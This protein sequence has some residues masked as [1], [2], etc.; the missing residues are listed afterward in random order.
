MPHGSF[1]HAALPHVASPHVAIRMFW[2]IETSDCVNLLRVSP[3]KASP[4][5]TPMPMICPDSQD[6]RAGPGASLDRHPAS[7]ALDG[8]AH[9]PSLHRHVPQVQQKAKAGELAPRC[10]PL[11]RV[12]DRG[13]LRPVRTSA[14][15]PRCQPRLPTTIIAAFEL[16]LRSYAPHERLWVWGSRSRAACL[17]PSHAALPSTVM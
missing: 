3:S 4:R 2:T 14:C 11:L 13:P 7:T 17:S 16:S 5:H 8:Q 15:A 9:Q 6:R 1:L 10:G 12:G